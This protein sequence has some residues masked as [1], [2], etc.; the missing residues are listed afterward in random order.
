MK[1]G[2]IIRDQEKIHFITATVVDWIDVFTRKTYKD[3]V[4]ESLAFCI[5]KKGMLLYGY[6]IMCNHIHLIIQS[7]TGKLSDLIRDFKKF[8]ATNI[9]EKIQTE[10]E[11][12]REWM[13]ERFK[14]ATETHNRN[15][16]YQFWQYGNH[17]EEVYSH[18]FMWSKLD[19]IHLN[20][21]RAGIVEKASHYRYSSA[22]NYVNN[23]GLVTIEIVDHPVIDVLKKA[24]ITK[25]NQY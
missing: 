8:T 21:V 5:E 24:S 6:V 13:L 4:I 2:Y 12:R 16:N 23:E 11:S 10:P 15:K 14:K 3:V 22:S 9:L 18:K 19:Y 1:E 17:A 7:K 20:P 25:Y